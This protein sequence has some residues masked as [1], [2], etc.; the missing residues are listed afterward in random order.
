MKNKLSPYTLGFTKIEKYIKASASFISDNIDRNFLFTT[1]DILHLLSSKPIG[2]ILYALSQI[3]YSNYYELHNL[4]GI[5]KIIIIRQI[6]RMRDYRI[7][8]P[9]SKASKEY[10]IQNHFWKKR[11]PNG[12]SNN[13]FYYLDPQFLGVIKHFENLLKSYFA[14]NSYL[15]SIENR[16]V[17]WLEHNK[18]VVMQFKAKQEIIKTAVGRCCNCNKL[19]VKSMKFEVDYR[20][21]GKN[22]LVCKNCYDTSSNDQIIKWMKGK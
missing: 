11:Y 9:L 1:I 8:L 17:S 7:V 21:L 22:T 19:I 12:L 4:A 6:S 16:K 20:R 18:I 2:K 10:K 5:D 15:E 3:S 13:T 14:G